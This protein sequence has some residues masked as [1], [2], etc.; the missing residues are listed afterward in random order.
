MELSS[1]KSGDGRPEVGAP[2]STSRMDEK[3]RQ[4]V[5]ESGSKAAS[6]VTPEEVDRYNK[7]KALYESD[8]GFRDIS[9]ADHTFYFFTYPFLLKGGERAA[10]LSL[11]M[12]MT[13]SRMRGRLD[14]K[15]TEMLRYLLDQFKQLTHRVIA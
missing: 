6:I 2:L 3:G 11:Q 15:S 1:V 9:E 10:A 12:L 5:D 7:I 4:A 8:S 14:H 13:R